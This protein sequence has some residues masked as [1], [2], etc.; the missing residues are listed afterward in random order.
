MILHTSNGFLR[1]AYKC[2]VS[3]YGVN[4]NNKHGKHH[5]YEGGCDR[6]V[7]IAEPFLYIIPNLYNEVGI[8]VS[9]L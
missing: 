9:V 7:T 4:N 3:V 8:I 2:L 6:P 1:H 5:I